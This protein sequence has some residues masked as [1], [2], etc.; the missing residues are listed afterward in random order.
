[1]CTPPLCP[2][3][4]RLTEALPDD[5]SG[6][7]KMDT[8]RLGREKIRSRMKIKKTNANGK[9]SPNRS[10]D[11]PLSIGEILQLYKACNHSLK[12]LHWGEPL[13][14]RLTPRNKI[15]SKVTID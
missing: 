15:I 5:D 6:E 8:G 14:S 11:Q 12:G 2:M 7:G 13:S 3:H 4:L 10:F 1:M 9:Y